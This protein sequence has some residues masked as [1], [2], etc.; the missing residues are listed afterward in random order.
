MVTSSTTASYGRSDR[1]E[2]ASRP[3]PASST[4]LPSRRSARS[5]D[6][7][8]LGSSSTT[9]M[10]LPFTVGGKCAQT[11]LRVGEELAVPDPGGHVRR[12]LAVDAA[13][14]EL[15]HRVLPLPAERLEVVALA[16]AHRPGDQLVVDALLVE[17]LLDLPTRM[18]ADLQPD[19]RAAV[20]LDGHDRHSRSRTGPRARRS[21]ASPG[22]GTRGRRRDRA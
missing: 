17:R 21:C 15:D 5:S 8:R 2:S 13:V 7:R 16:A 14:L 12:L 19:I 10:R 9:R 3:S 22:P 20:E 4:E 6:A 11:R 18:G 1:A